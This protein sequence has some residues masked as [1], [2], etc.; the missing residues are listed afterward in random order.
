M[1]VDWPLE[2]GSSKGTHVPWTW[3]QTLNAR[4]EVWGVED[5]EEPVLLRT[6]EWHEPERDCPS[7][8]TPG[9]RPAGRSES[10]GQRAMEAHMSLFALPHLPF[11]ATVFT[12]CQQ[13]YGS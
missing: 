7:P 1:G 5:G 4:A 9:P 13:S 11:Q 10:Q 6:E 2:K 12:A 8:L 3:S